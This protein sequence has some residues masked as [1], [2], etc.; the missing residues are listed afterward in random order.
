MSV[1]YVVY[2]MVSGLILIQN[3]NSVFVALNYQKL[4]QKTKKKKKKSQNNSLIIYA[5]WQELRN[6]YI[7]IHAYWVKVFIWKSEDDRCLHWLKQCE[8]KIHG[9]DWFW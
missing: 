6:E 2:I 1:T 8:N 9:I 7:C 5:S 4:D 3:L